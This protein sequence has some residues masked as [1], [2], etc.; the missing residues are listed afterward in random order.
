M[1]YLSSGLS[2]DVEAVACV[3]VLVKYSSPERNITY[4]YIIIV[5]LPLTVM[6]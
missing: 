3:K 4:T 2:N 6:R 5:F 1:L